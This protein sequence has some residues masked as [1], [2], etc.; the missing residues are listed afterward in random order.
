MSQNHK[1]TETTTEKHEEA[2]VGENSGARRE[3][4][5]FLSLE[6]EISNL[7]SVLGAF[8]YQ[9]VLFIKQA[10]CSSCSLPSLGFSFEPS[11]HTFL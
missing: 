3:G 5:Q 6:C 7:G 2:S 11:S 4:K 9:T 10:K 8:S 1:S